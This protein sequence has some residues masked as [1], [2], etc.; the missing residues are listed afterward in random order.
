M[1]APTLACYPNPVNDVLTLQW[2]NVMPGDLQA[3][4]LDAT[5]RVCAMRSFHFAR[6]GSVAWDLRAL[7]PGRYMMLTASGQ[8]SWRSAVMKL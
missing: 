6:T 3:R 2:E 1:A 8:F 4:L 7:P 5:G